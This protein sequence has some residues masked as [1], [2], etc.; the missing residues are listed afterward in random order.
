MI[1]RLAVT[2]V[3]LQLSR[4]IGRHLAEKVNIGHHVTHTQP[5][6]PQFNQHAIQSAAKHLITK[7]LISSDTIFPAYQF[8]IAHAAY[9]IVPA[10]GIFSNTAENAPH[11]G[12]ASVALGQTERMLRLQRIRHVIALQFLFL[13]EE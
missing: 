12:M 7:L 11:V 9:G 1:A 5:P 3:K 4:G 2:G 13:I 8:S 6:L 10:R